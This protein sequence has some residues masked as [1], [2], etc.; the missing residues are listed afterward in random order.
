MLLGIFLYFGIYLSQLAFI[1]KIDGIHK[2]NE[3]KLLPIK[4]K[5]FKYA[6][7]HYTRDYNINNERKLFPK[8]EVY[9][10]S[11]EIISLFLQILAHMLYIVF[12]II[13]IQVYETNNRIFSIIQMIIFCLAIIYTIG[14]MIY[15][16]VRED[17]IKKNYIVK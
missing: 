14:L 17:R 12:I 15:Q 10:N 3:N 11:I 5:F 6:I 13:R 16:G 2:Y 7:I 1:W 9:K 8:N 4:P